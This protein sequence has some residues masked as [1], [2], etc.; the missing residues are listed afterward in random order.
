[1]INN[2]RNKKQLYNLWYNWYCASVP[3]IHDNRFE[4]KNGVPILCNLLSVNLPKQMVQ[5]LRDY[6]LNEV[7]VADDVLDEFTAIFGELTEL[8]SLVELG[9]VF[10]KYMLFTEDYLSEAGERHTYAISPRDY[11]TQD[12]TIT[13]VIHNKRIEIT[14]T[15]EEGS[16]LESY[17]VKV[18]DLK[19]NTHT[20]KQLNYKPYAEQYFNQDYQYQDGKSLF[21]DSLHALHQLDFAYT[22]MYNTLELGRNMIVVSQEALSTVTVTELY[23]DEDNEQQAKVER[24]KYLA[25]NN[26]AFQI[27]NSPF[28]PDG[29][30][31]SP[32]QHIQGDLKVD[33]YEQAINLHIQIATKLAGFDNGYFRYSVSQG[34]TATAITSSK[35]DMYRT[36]KKYQK[37]LATN[38]VSFF[39]QAFRTENYQELEP[40]VITFGDSL[41]TNDESLK[42]QGNHLYSIGAI[43]KEYLLTGYYGYSEDEV[44]KAMPDE[45][46]EST[47]TDPRG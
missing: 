15:E 24:Q 18:T 4:E 26:R 43:S 17:T 46:E 22:E 33:E 8:E 19:D 5:H 25:R 35:S 20:E 36:V 31:N 3:S 10:G 1:M 29:S 9:L 40:K 30:N 42:E 41:L 47:Y 45:P 21:A 11:S 44:K 13:F 14:E 39:N 38:L 23:T 16:V 27:I 28:H 6:I 12:D 34:I 7:E 37:A 32:I 2:R